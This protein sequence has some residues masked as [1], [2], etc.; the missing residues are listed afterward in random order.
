MGK[1]IKE[2]PQYRVLYVEGAET[3]S[4]RRILVTA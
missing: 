4:Y 2:C 3:L 1:L